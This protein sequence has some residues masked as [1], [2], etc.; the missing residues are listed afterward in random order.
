VFDLSLKLLTLH[1][2]HALTRDNSVLSDGGCGM[3]RAFISRTLE[4]V[5]RL[6]SPC[7][8]ARHAPSRWLSTRP[9]E[10]SL[11]ANRRT[12]P[13]TSRDVQYAGGGAVATRSGRAVGTGDDEFVAATSAAV[14]IRTAASTT[15]PDR[16]IIAL[17]GW[18]ML[19]SRTTTHGLIGMCDP[20]Q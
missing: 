18:F 20:V 17:T 7:G 3:L 19:S 13:V 2:L 11:V 1:T 14:S 8:R 15:A 9:L 12:W 4:H 6:A 10:R 16:R 5:E